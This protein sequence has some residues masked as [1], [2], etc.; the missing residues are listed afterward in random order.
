LSD[1]AHRPDFDAPDSSPGNTQADL[2][3][4]RSMT[5]AELSKELLFLLK[6]KADVANTNRS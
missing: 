2:R 1:A 3:G 5:P 4:A 6:P